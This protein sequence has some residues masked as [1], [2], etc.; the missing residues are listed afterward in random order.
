MTTCRVHYVKTREH[1]P[2]NLQ[3]GAFL[4]FVTAFMLTDVELQ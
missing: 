4:K 1:N 3:T 2:L